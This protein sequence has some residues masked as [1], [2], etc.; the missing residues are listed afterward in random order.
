MLLVILAGKSDAHAPHADTA[1][2]QTY[3]NEHEKCI[4]SH[5]GLHITSTLS[6]TN[7]SLWNKEREHW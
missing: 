6:L 1:G 3:K 2:Q 7:E 5:G 4:H